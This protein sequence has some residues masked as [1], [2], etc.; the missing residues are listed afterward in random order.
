[1][2]EGVPDPKDLLNILII[3]TCA[4]VLL[5][6]IYMLYMLRVLMNELNPAA[7]RKPLFSNLIKKLSD[8][9]PVEDEHSILT[10]HNYDGIHELDNNLPLWWKYMFYLSIVCA[11]VYF[12]YYHFS[13][14]G[15]LQIEEYNHEVLMADKEVAEYMKRSA[16][17]VDENNVKRLTEP[18]RIESGKVLFL[19]NCAACHGKG[20]E[21]G[22][23]PNL[24]DE[25]WLHGGGVK[26]V[27]K[28][29]KYGVSQKGMISWKTQLSPGN[30]QEV[31][32]FILT[33]KDT[34]PDHP[35]AAQ[36]ERYEEEKEVVSK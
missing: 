24:T 5:V 9:V 35:K 31:T 12:Y 34:H 3:S 28:T 30:M 19:Q 36:G 20:G 4:F 16:N 32:S 22:V 33:L 23:G 13:G 14:Y 8:A 21:G 10:D 11:G 17:S 18:V 15:K 2:P 7:I 1:M 27:F 26:N 6:L 29:I 25:Y